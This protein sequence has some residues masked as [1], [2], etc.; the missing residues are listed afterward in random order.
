VNGDRLIRA[1]TAAVVVG[2]AGVAA[3]VSYRHAYQV[4]TSHGESGATAALIPLTIDGLVFCASMV[5]LDVAR[6]GERAPA[7]ARAALALGVGAT[8]AAN[9]LHGIAAGPVGAVIS[10]WPA[11]CLVLVAEL[12]MGMIRR[13]RIDRPQPVTGTPADPAEPVAEPVAGPAPQPP[14]ISG[15]SGTTESDDTAGRTP[16]DGLRSAVVS[17]HE[18][19]VA[20]TR[21]AAE[22]GISR[23][24]LD[25][26]LGAPPTPGVAASNGHST[27]VR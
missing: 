25:R 12:L 27:E 1:S 23:Y 26:L 16:V 14:K 13:G 18:S 19:G 6:R 7:L 20:K 5:L 17:A 22:F 24:R 2:V 9:V 15:G 21:I 4:A 11:V 3:F 8:V 10:A